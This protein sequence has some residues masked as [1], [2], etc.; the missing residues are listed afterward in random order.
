MTPP[1]KMRTVSPGPMRAGVRLA[2]ER[3]AD[4]LQRRSRRRRRG[5]RSERPSRPSPSCRDPARRSARSTSSASTRSSAA[6]MW[7]ALGAPSP[8]SGTAG[9]A[10]APGPPASSSDRSRRRRRLRAA[11]RVC[12]SRNPVAGRNAILEPSAGR[13]SACHDNSGDDERQRQRTARRAPAGSSPGMRCTSVC[14]I[15]KRIDV[16]AIRIVADAV[17]RGQREARMIGDDEHDVGQERREQRA[18]REAAGIH[19]T[20]SDRDGRGR[21]ATAESRRATRTRA[22][23]ARTAARARAR[24]MSF[25]RAAETSP[26]A[27]GTSAISATHGAA[28]QSARRASRPTTPASEQRDVQAQLDRQRPQRAVDVVRKRIVGKRARQAGTRMSHAERDV[29]TT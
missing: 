6:R 2:G 4:A 19:A 5:R 10:R 13:S 17:E 8:A 21:P 9:S 28:S 20:S 24:R 12:S 15:G 7:H 26:A 18:A 25:G 22:S 11:S 14:W 27:R 29:A 1:V 3:F 16:D 23:P